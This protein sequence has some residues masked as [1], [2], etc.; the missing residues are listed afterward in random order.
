MGKESYLEVGTSSSNDLGGFM[1]IEPMKNSARDTYR[2]ALL[3]TLIVPTYPILWLLID[4]SIDAWHL[5]TFQHDSNVNCINYDAFDPGILQEPTHF[6]C[7]LM[8]DD[9]T[10][11]IEGSI[12]STGWTSGRDDSQTSQLH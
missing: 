4:P 7:R 2:A 3:E 6:L 1:A 5:G 9:S 8:R 10:D 12:Q 11:Q